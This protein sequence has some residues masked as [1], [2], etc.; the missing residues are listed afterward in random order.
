MHIVIL[1]KKG[2]PKSLNIKDM[3]FDTLYKKAGFKSANGFKK[4]REFVLSTTCIE[5]YG[6]TS[7][8]TDTENLDEIFQI[9]Q[10]DEHGIPKAP[11]YGNAV[12]VMKQGLEYISLTLAEWETK[13][14]QIL[15]QPYEEDAIIE[16][17]SELESE[18]SL[19]DADSSNPDTDQSD[20]DIDAADADADRD[21]EEEYSESESDGVA[22]ATTEP[23]SEMEV[24]PC[25][26]LVGGERGGRNKKKKLEKFKLITLEELEY[27]PYL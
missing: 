17:D 2:G 27:E 18:T 20:I 22:E 25:L 10:L 12:V 5:V 16:E 9:P 23:T 21:S 4:Q 26:L 19:S 14:K 6:K 24:D 15:Q 11:I 1:D 13:K 7:G 3:N 8:K